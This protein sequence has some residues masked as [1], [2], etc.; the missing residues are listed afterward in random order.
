MGTE[1]GDG[2]L[3]S[4]SNLL[5]GYKKAEFGDEQHK[6]RMLWCWVWHWTAV[7]WWVSKQWC[8]GCQSS[9]VMGVKKAVMWWVSKQWCDGCQRLEFLFGRMTG[10]FWQEWACMEYIRI[11]CLVRI[12]YLV[13]GLC[14]ITGCTDPDICHPDCFLVLRF[15]HSCFGLSMHCQPIV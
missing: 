13:G 6:D 11:C 1:D 9:D 2:E 15:L 12:R 8:D 5:D 14:Y 3:L 7:T 4:C 10:M